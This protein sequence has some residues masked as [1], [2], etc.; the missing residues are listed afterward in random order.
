MNIRLSDSDTPSLGGFQIPYKDN[1]PEK[2][3][4]RIFQL[5]D[6][7][8]VFDYQNSMTSE[9]RNRLN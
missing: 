6:K 3:V 4:E 1:T 8:N 2:R 7:V 9:F 5:M